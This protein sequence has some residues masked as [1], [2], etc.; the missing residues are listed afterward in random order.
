MLGNLG[1]PNDNIF[2]IYEL[3]PT[4]WNF[5]TQIQL[6]M[7]E[8]SFFHEVLHT[9]CETF[10]MTSQIFLSYGPQLRNH[11]NLGLIFSWTLILH[12]ITNQ[13]KQWLT[14][15]IFLA[16]ICTTRAFWLEV[17]NTSSCSLGSV[18]LVQMSWISQTCPSRKWEQPRPFF[19]M[20]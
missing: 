12:E 19:C 11:H 14:G 20:G 16:I 10:A 4:R 6:E 15:A 1:H 13:G 8:L 7:V 5:P 3:L 18:E 9:R 2:W 17:L